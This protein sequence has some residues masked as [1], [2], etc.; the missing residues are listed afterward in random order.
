VAR[1]KLADVDALVAEAMAEW[2]VPGLALAIVIDDEPVLVRGY[3][4]RD[5]EASLPVTPDTQFLIAS[6]TKS[7][8]AAGIGTLVDEGKLGW[9]TRVRDIIPEF[10]LRDQ[11]ATERV[12]VH[13]LLCHRTGLPRH[14]WAWMPGD[15][16]CAEIFDGLRHLDASQDMRAGTQ[17][18]NLGYMVAAMVAERIAGKPWETFIRERLFDPLRMTRAGFSY[19]DLEASTDAATPYIFRP[20]PKKSWSFRDGKRQR[21]SYLRVKSTGENTASASVAGMANH[22]RGAGGLYASISDMVNY[23]RFHL[24][25][26]RFD[27]GLI[28]S[29]DRVR[30]MRTPYAFGGRPDCAELSDWHFGL[31]L[32]SQHYRGER[33]VHHGGGWYGV[34]SRFVLLPDRRTG[35]VILCN[36]N[37][38]GAVQAIEYS[39]LDRLSD[40]APLPWI[41]RA[42]GEHKAWMEVQEQAAKRPSSPAPPKKG[43][44]RPLEDY[45]GSYAHPAFGRIEIEATADGVLCNYRGLLGKIVHRR[46]DTFALEGTWEMAPIFP[47]GVAATFASNQEGSIDR[48]FLPLEPAVSPI[49]FNRVGQ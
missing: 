32:W 22:L 13:D 16:S 15:L 24:A 39:I 14:D 33:I 38:D 20:D 47:S 6:L 36:D 44:I 11:N 2:C 49:V 21:T 8:T 34:K 40:K 3:G 23:L 1:E 4:F 31:G 27:G 25:E 42:R 17:Y 48:V 18:C 5:V 37:V 10:Q 26:G 35:L 45:A 41:D 46:E 28:L 43:P 9:W 30:D 12:T 29:P 19:A 7:F